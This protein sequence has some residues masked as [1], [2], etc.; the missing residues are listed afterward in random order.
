[1]LGDLREGQG[2]NQN[3]L[4]KA[5]RGLQGSDNRV[6]GA[7]HDTEIPCLPHWPQLLREA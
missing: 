4:T 1:M 7:G 3:V 5:Y 2:S 6:M